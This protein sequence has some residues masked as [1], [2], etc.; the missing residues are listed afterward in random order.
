M[1]NPRI[2]GMVIALFLLAWTGMH[3]DIQVVASGSV[4]YVDDDYT[5]AT[6]GWQVD[7][8]ASIHEGIDAVPE[9]GTVLVS[10]GA[11]REHLVIDKP[12]HLK[13]NG[14]GRKTID[15]T[16]SQQVVSITADLVTIQG[17]IITNGSYGI[18]LTNVSNITILDNTIRQTVYGIFLDQGKNITSYQNN[19]IDNTHHAYDDNANQWDDGTAGNY[20][21]DYAGIDANDNGIGDS[22]YLIA[23]GSAQ[24]KYPQMAPVTTP[25][26]AAFTVTPE[27]PTTQTEVQFS[28]NSTDIDG[29]IIA[30][31][32][33]FG[34]GN[35]SIIHHPSHTYTDDGIYMVTLTVTDDLGVTNHTVLYLTVTNV[36]PVI[37][38]TY[39][40]SIP[41]DLD[42]IVFID[43]SEDLD[44]TIV[45]WLWEFGDGNASTLQQP[46]H[47][48]AD[49]G[50]Y[51]VQLTVTD[52]DGAD[53]HL[54]QELTVANVDP[55]AAFSYS[56]VTPTTNDTIKFTDTSRDDDGTIVS[57]Q[58][59][60]G[61]GTTS[62]ERSPSHHY[63]EGRTYTISLT[64]VDDDGASDTVT[65]KV[66]I[67]EVSA[68]SQDYGG[69]VI[70]FVLFF[71]LF[72][73]MIGVVLWLNKKHR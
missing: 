15:G 33:D 41:T 68:Q 12:L 43:N 17:F 32:W 47:T 7:H 35:I 25:P 66:A 72:G 23:G 5:A 57:W 1:K 44:G 67:T 49:D 60:L 26:R 40:P 18:A 63:S 22:P 69:F 19:F 3:L 39:A 9:N 24:D 21:D 64:V 30:W 10:E 52:D 55:Q 46:T 56:P 13:G 11:Y 54:S 34:D 62:T 27:D 53:A 6:E 28:D 8:F 2:L 38:F 16:G 73:I 65:K 45:A 29:Q 59:D 70:I 14:T 42:E 51:G 61:D 48:Y 58:W 4:I 37:S 36:A 20:W 71:V 50:V 31:Q